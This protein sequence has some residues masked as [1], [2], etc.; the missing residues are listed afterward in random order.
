MSLL[1]S[2]LARVL[3][4]HPLQVVI[5]TTLVAGVAYLSV[6]D[7]YLGLV[8]SA[9]TVRFLPLPG[10]WQTAATA[11]SEAPH[12]FARLVQFLGVA[13]PEIAGCVPVDSA[14]CW[15]VSGEAAPPPAS[16]G[17]LH[18][19]ALHRFA[20]YMSAVHAAVRHVRASVQDDSFLGAIVACAYAATAYQVVSLFAAMRRC[21]LRFWL[22]FAALV[23]LTFA[24]LIAVA[25]VTQVIKVPLGMLSEGLPFL[26]AGVGLNGKSVLARHVLRNQHRAADA[27]VGRAVALHLVRVARDTAAA[28]ALCAILAHVIPQFRP[29][30]IVGAAACALD[31]FLTSTFFAASLALKVEL[32]QVRLH[33]DTVAQLEDEGLSE[34]AAER[35]AGAL[36]ALRFGHEDVALAFKFAMAV[37]ASLLFLMFGPWRDVWSSRGLLRLP[38]EVLAESVPAPAVVEILLPLVYA[39]HGSLLHF[40]HRALAGVAYVSRLIREPVISKTLLVACVLSLVSNAYFLAGFRNH[41]VA[42]ASVSAPALAPAPAPAPEKPAPPSRGT[43]APAELTDAIAVLKAGNA[44]TLSDDTLVLLVT[45]LHLPLYALEKTLKD[46]TRAVEIRRASL[47]SLANAP[48]LTLG[49]LP[50]ANYDYDRV[51]GACCENVIGY[52]PLPVG[53]VGP[54]LIDGTAYHVPMATTEGCLVALAMRGAKAINA[55]GGCT[56]VLVQD[57]MLRGPA[58]SFPLL[59]RAAQCDAWVRLEEGEKAL[60]AAFNLTLRFARLSKLKPQIAGHTLFI[61]FTTTTGDAMGMN[62]ILKGVEKALEF[63]KT[64]VFPDMVVVAVLGNYCTDKKA[65]AINWIEGRG[66][67]VVAEA[68]V[69]RLV[70]EK[71]LKLDVDA[72][73]LMNT[74]KNLVGSAMAGALGGFNAHAANL[75]TAVYLATGQDPAQNVELLNCITLM[76]KVGEDLRISV[77]MPL[78]EVG[79]IG[80]GTILGPQGAMLELL[81][82]RGAHRETPGANARQLAR[83]VAATVLLGELSL[84]AALAAGHLVQLHMQHNRAAPAAP[85][86]APAEVA[87]LQQG[88]VT[89]LK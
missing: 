70:V 77:T 15:L 85:A 51:L 39:P 29:F 66:K 8:L 72:L 11:P 35:A 23:L 83:I 26:A 14:H 81:G 52:M 4:R 47:A 10:V 36:A 24:L 33:A 44:S 41:K 63:M 19:V 88:A 86:A 79:T 38:M 57:G 50:Y 55:G 61:R 45:S 30:F 84:C 20:H 21:G 17:V 78:I 32:T 27:A 31:I 73:V 22:G 49:L 89:C 56:T 74:T 69:P 5:A 43:L 28:G 6:V 48:V 58:V 62:M 25:A 75:V 42:P 46:T 87:R 34:E 18:L 54:Y 37:G 59:E 40:V 60:K 1:L 2:G 13:M 68:V 76:D 53:I 3:A 16:F 67:S 7:E 9:N 65:A 64:E 80:G 71:V 12:V 82:V